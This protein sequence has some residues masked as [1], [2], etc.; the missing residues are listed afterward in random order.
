MATASN[1]KGAIPRAITELAMCALFAAGGVR[2]DT[3]YRPSK[4]SEDVPSLITRFKKQAA[5]A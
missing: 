2:T 1:A 3:L 4:I 5:K